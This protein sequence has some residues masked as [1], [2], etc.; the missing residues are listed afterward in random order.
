MSAPNPEARGV[1]HWSKEEDDFLKE[2]VEEVPGKNWT[3]ISAIVS[4][5]FPKTPKQCRDRYNNYLAPNLDCTSILWTDEDD[6]KILELYYKFGSKWTV[7][8]KEMPGKSAN[9]IKNRWNSSI[10]KRVN[11][12]T[13][14]LHKY[15]GRGKPPKHSALFPPKICYSVP[16]AH[17]YPMMAQNSQSVNP[18][19]APNND[20]LKQDG[21][22]SYMPTASVPP[23]PSQVANND[24]LKQDGFISYM[25]R[26]EPPQMSEPAPV[27]PPAPAPVPPPESMNI[28]ALMNQKESPKQPSSP[29]EAPNADP[30]VENVAITNPKVALDNLLNS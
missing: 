11:L 1:K 2:V 7:I 17:A 27:Q 24:W 8:A 6:I 13:G 21:F 29:Q 16:L 25:P 22:I 18:Y 9:V 30:I 28:H 26:F 12:S 19:Y 15:V 10:R 3:Q 20:W 23:P 5:K 4:K 14:T